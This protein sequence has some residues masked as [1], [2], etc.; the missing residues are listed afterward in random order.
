MK[1]KFWLVCIGLLLLICG[2]VFADGK[3]SENFDIATTAEENK[4]I[5]D[6]DMGYMG[7][8]SIAMFAL[9]QADKAGYIELLGITA[10]GGNSLLAPGTAAILNQLERLGRTDIPVYMG[11]DIPLK[12]FRNLEADAQ[13]YGQFGWTGGYRQLE[14][15]TTDY[16]NLGP[17]ENEEWGLPETLAEEMHAADFMIEQ[18]HKY[19]GQVTIFA[20]GACTNVAIAV[21]KDPTFAENAAGI[22]YM[23]GAIDVPGNTTPTAEFNWWYDPDAAAV[24]LR[25]NW[26]YQLVVPH[27]V[28]PKVLMAKDV[29]D[30]YAEK[31]HSAVTELLVEKYG[32]RYEENPTS[33]SYCW[34]PIT[35]GV[36]LCPDL[37]KT[38][39]IRDIAI[40][41]SPGYTY[42]KAVTWDLGKGPYNSSEATIVL[43]VDRD[44]FWTFMSDLFGEN[45]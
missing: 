23:G 13:V 14:H 15:Y 18:V 45:F 29:Y 10:V 26:N 35:V 37:I 33:T 20:V 39:E 27:D 30:L 43:D 44:G 5:F 17:L 24:A 2:N 25:A 7:D 32:P 40:E 34:D 3:I 31:N 41:T 36:F 11:T 42:G 22:V 4:V 12:G 1:R 6:T 21:M 16:K 28:A 9:L 38:S 19:P 8:D